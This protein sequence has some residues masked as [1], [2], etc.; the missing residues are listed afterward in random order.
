V[1][2]ARVAFDFDVAGKF[3]GTEIEQVRARY[4]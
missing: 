2:Y 1:G 3:L 4:H